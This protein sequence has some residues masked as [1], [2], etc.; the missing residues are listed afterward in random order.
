MF[1]ALLM[2]FASGLPLLLTGKTLQAWLHD[3]KVTLTTIGLYALVG[4]PYTLK[5]IWAP[6]F[7]INIFKGFGR[8]RGWML[9][10]Q[11]GLVLFIFLLANFKPSQ[12]E[13][14]FVLLALGVSFF[15]ACQDIAIDAFRRDSLQENEL[16]LGSTMYLYGYR[17]AMLIS[18]AVALAM[19][20]YMN[21]KQV[22]ISM[23]VVMLISTLPTLFADEP[24][25]HTSGPKNLY[26]SVILPFKD[27]LS[28]ENAILI[29]SFILLY[30]VGD[31]IAGAMST[32]FYLKIGFSK[33]QIAAITKVL[34]LVSTL[35]GAFIGGAI[36]LKAGI[37]RSLWLFGILQSLSTLGFALLAKMGAVT[38]LLAGVICFEDL[39]GGMGTAAFM[40]Y[41]ASLTNKQYTATQYAL[42]TSIMG[43]P[44]V[45]ISSASGALAD[46]LGWFLFFIFCAITALPGLLILLKLK[47]NPPQEAPPQK[48]F[49]ASSTR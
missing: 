34:G 49:I 43:V 9:V 26:D 7:D 11:L 33:T 22:Y 17:V 32:P 3:E 23:A 29:L 38:W 1:F 8:R 46:F 40:A 13:L 15:S 37:Y 47:P 16:G 44:R 12:M 45:L 4:L 25:A 19:A 48:E 18:G 35:T 30:K 28:R 14:A 6:V 2:G 41:L 31:T 20:D 5:F 21:W 42:L 24:E 10:N 39:S 36:I 27:F